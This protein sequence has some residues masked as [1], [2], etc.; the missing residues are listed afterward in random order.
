MEKKKQPINKFYYITETKNKLNYI[1][2]TLFGFS[3][4]E[5]R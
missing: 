1:F 5:Q 3:I 2:G 4:I